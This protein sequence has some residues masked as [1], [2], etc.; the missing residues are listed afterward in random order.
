M[1]VSP[2]RDEP[3]VCICC[4]LQWFWNK[5]KKKKK[6]EKVKS[7]KTYGFYKSRCNSCAEH[8]SIYSQVA[9]PPNHN[10][11][12]VPLGPRGFTEAKWVVALKIDNSYTK[13]E[14]NNNHFIRTPSCL[15]SEWSLSEVNMF[16]PPLGGGI[17]SSTK[18]LLYP[19]PVSRPI[20]WRYYLR[21]IR[22]VRFLIRTHGHIKVKWKTQMWIW[23]Y[24]S[25]SHQSLSLI[26]IWRCRRWT[27]CR[28]RWAPYH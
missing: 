18:C 19:F 13:R 6:S 3:K 16:L 20:T 22:P 14:G 1:S 24:I 21:E 5:I 2:A 8:I 9:W 4:K 27:L 17:F 7:N 23:L 12:S 26:H 11:K 15:N 28:S 25:M 10:N